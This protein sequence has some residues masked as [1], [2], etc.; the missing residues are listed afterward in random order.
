MIAS[1]SRLRTRQV[2]NAVYNK[3][4]LL[5]VYDSFQNLLFKA[6]Y[7]YSLQ[8]LSLMKIPR[9]ISISHFKGWVV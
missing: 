9:S 1:L 2:T 3:D 7:S 6:K 8:I 4:E 5:G